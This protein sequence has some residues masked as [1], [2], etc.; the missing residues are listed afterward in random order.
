MIQFEQIY[1]MYF[2]DVYKYSL[3]LSGNESTAEDIT[4]ETFFRAMNAIGKFRGDC[5]I[6]VWL[7]QIAK[8]L[9]YNHIKKEKRKADYNENEIIQLEDPESSTEEMIIRSDE[10][11][12]IRILLHELKEPYK[13]VFMWRVYGEMSFKQIGELF[14]KT[15]NWACVTYY[16]AKT[17]IGKRLEENT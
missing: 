13:E 2:N 8:N 5:D 17:M 11:D 6:R 16:R 9:Y 1:K 10:A 7:C 14:G 15:E 3:K 4:C 12:R